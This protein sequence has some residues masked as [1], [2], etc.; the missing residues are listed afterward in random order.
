MREIGLKLKEKASLIEPPSDGVRLLYFNMLNQIRDL[1][2]I[3]T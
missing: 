2:K 3:T 1:E